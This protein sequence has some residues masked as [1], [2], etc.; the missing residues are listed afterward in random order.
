MCVAAA[1]GATLAAVLFPPVAVAYLAVLAPARDPG[2]PPGRV[3]ARVAALWHAWVSSGGYLPWRTWSALALRH[4]HALLVTLGLMTLAGGGLAYASGR[5]RGTRTWGG[6]PAAGKGQHGTARWRTPAELARSL[7]LWQW[8]ASKPSNPS[9]V[10]V[11]RGPRRGTA[12]VLKG[13]GHALLLG[14]TGA[15]KSRRIILPSIG[16]IGEAARESLIVTDPKGE[17]YAH[18]AEWLRSR[19]Y[20][21]V[22][23]DLRQPATGNRWNPVLPVAEALAAGQLDRASAA[24]WDVAHVLTY[25]AEYRGTDPI[26]PQSQEALIAALI[27]AVAQGEPPPGGKAPPEGEPWAWPSAEQQHMGSVYAALLAG[28]EGG[29]RLDDWMDQFPPDHPAYKAYG[30]VR[31]SVERTRAS[32]LTGAAAELRLFADQEV[33]WLTSAQDHDLA[34]P[35]RRPTAVFLV[36]PDERSTRYPLATLYVQ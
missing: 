7:A 10:L 11:G 12:W 18:A 21:V 6:P 27:L 30:P 9:G 5:G 4:P 22:R 23:I 19:G 25:S 3:A 29:T 32:I 28:G 26:W 24:A 15:G 17:L 36:I 13:D 33:A 8:Q 34:A 14:S 31:L 2:A 35:G 16:V 1:F 20:D